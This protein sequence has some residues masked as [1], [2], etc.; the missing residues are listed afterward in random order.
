MPRPFAAVAPLVLLAVVLGGGSA[1]AQTRD[2]TIVISR[3]DCARAVRHVPAPDV[4]HRPGLDVQ[5]RPVAP[6]DLPGTPKIQLPET[7]EIEITVDLQDRLGL[8]ADPGKYA[9]EAKVGKVVYR[10]GRA[11]FDGQPLTDESQ[12]RLAAACAEWQRRD[13]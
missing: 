7:I 1:G 6:A 5:G 2:A 3:D 4:A 12:A 10:D 11:W 13:R 9:G 8:P